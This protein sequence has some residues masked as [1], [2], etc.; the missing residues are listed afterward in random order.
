M[1]RIEALKLLTLKSPKHI[2][3]EEMAELVSGADTSGGQNGNKNDMFVQHELFDI[4]NGHP[5][6]IGLTSSL[7]K[8]KRL[9]EVYHILS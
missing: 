4:L 2:S 6:A 5:Q 1:E 7:L 9:F 3:E 8:E